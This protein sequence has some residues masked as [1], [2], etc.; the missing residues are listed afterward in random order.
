VSAKQ[1]QLVE[2]VPDGHLVV[3]QNARHLLPMEQ[4]VALNQALLTW[5]SSC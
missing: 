1:S 5:L 2:A 4:P 3:I